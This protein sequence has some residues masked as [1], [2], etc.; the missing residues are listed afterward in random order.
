M[1]VRAFWLR[2]MADFVARVVWL[3][4]RAARRVGMN[5]VVDGRSGFIG[6]SCSYAALMMRS[7]F[8]RSYGSDDGAF[9]MGI[10][11]TCRSFR[12]GL[13]KSALEYGQTIGV[14]CLL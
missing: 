4:I 8:R 7:C 14:T 1:E 3:M 2:W 11:A 12:S 9:G 10:V 5:E 6:V 13:V